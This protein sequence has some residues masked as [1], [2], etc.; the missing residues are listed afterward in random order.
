MWG[1][2]RLMDANSLLNAGCKAGSRGHGSGMLKLVIATHNAH[3][4]EE[5]RAM[6]S[7]SA[8]V[9]DLSA[10]PEIPAADET[11]VTFEENA[12]IKALE[13]GKVLGGD[14]LVLSDDSGLEV[15]VLGKEPGVYSSRYAGEEATDADNRAKL[16]AELEK[17]GA[18]GKERTG[19]FRCTM[20]LARGAEKLAVLDGSVEGLL[21]TVEKGDGGFG[22]DALFIPDGFCETFA[23]LPAETKNELSHRARALEKV[24]AYLRSNPAI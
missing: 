13:A 9:E 7:G 6:L 4:T 23:Q 21:G 15:D 18:K 14:V 10:Y 11:G 8:E 2:G 19:R 24:V 3:K 20:V 16:I 12:T 1:F 5:I 17:S 22:Y